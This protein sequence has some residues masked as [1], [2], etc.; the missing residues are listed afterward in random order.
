MVA[1]NNRERAFKIH[2]LGR[3][4]PRPKL[5]RVPSILLHRPHPLQPHLHPG[6]HDILNTNVLP[7]KKFL[8]L[9]FNAS[10]HIQ[11]IPHHRLLSDKQMLPPMVPSKGLRRLQVSPNPR[12][13][14]I[15]PKNHSP[16]GLVSPCPRDPQNG[17]ALP[18]RAR[19]L[20]ILDTK[21]PY[22]YIAVIALCFDRY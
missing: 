13:S 12:L 17:C 10:T 8:G 20:G 15:Q 2:P 14:K 18:H 16:D 3:T 5:P 1:H 7:P 21:Y 11:P 9:I 6:A 4:T 22:V 19:V